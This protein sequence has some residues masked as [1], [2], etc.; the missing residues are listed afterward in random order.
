MSVN[1]LEFNPLYL[2]KH[3]DEIRKIPRPSKKEKAIGDYVVSIAKAYGY[4]YDRDEIG[5]IVIRV[6]ASPGCESANIVILQSHLDMVCEKNSDVEFDFDNDAIQLR[7]EGDWL[8]AQGTTLGSDNGIGVAALLAAMDDPKLVHGPL[9]LL[10]TIDE[11]TGLTGAA[12]LRTDFLKGKTLI[13]LDSEEEGNFSI[14][15]AGGADTRIRLTLSQVT[16][17]PG[18]FIRVLLSGFK[19]GHSGIDINKNRANTIKLLARILWETSRKVD[20][21]LANFHGGNA[22]NAIPRE[23]FADL[24]VSKDDNSNLRENLEESFKQINLEYKS[25]ESA[26]GITIKD[27]E[28]PHEKVLDEQTQKTVLNFLYALPHGVQKMSADIPGL[29][30]TSVN[31][32]TIRLQEGTINILMSARSSVTPALKATGDRLEAFAGLAGAEVEREPGYPG[33]TPNLDSYVL[34]VAKTC[35]KNLAGKEPVVEAIHAG[36]ECGIIGEKF[37]GMDMISIG[38]QIEHPHSPDERVHIS[39][40]ERFWDLLKSMLENLVSQK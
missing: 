20:F 10:F 36:L 9:E 4:E 12:E 6:P 32:A 22:H 16:P 2:W 19:G 13:N 34:Q 27:I 25:V 26:G 7:Q 23:A 37:P 33:W 1:I 18:R 5:T 8:Y 14:G 31:L 3:F 39:S 17:K 24:W 15:C 38:P 28:E 30:E 21:R 35:Y 11:E 29:V 40:V